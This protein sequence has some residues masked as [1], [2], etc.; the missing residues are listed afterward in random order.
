MRLKDRG[1]DLALKLWKRVDDLT[2]RMVGNSSSAPGKDLQ[3]NQRSDRQVEILGCRL[4]R[5][6][7]AL[8]VWRLCRPAATALE[9]E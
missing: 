5:Y 8:E 7:V 6:E 2:R 4:R 9:G 3:V 1:I